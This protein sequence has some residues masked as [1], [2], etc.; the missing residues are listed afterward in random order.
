MTYTERLRAL[1]N[2][3][4]GR[5]GREVARASRLMRGAFAGIES[6]TT[7][8]VGRASD[9]AMLDPD[10]LEELKQTSPSMAI[11][12]LWLTRHRTG[13]GDYPRIAQVRRSYAEP[14]PYGVTRVVV[15]MPALVDHSLSLTMLGEAAEAFPSAELCCF[16]DVL[17][18]RAAARTE[19]AV[20]SMTGRHAQVDGN[21]RFGSARASGRRLG[22]LLRESDALT[23]DAPSL[24]PPIVARSMLRQADNRPAPPSMTP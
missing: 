13:N 6:K 21:L 24:F 22:R 17:C 5:G 23:P 7:A 19:A 3:Y 14:T 10:E 15:L 9:L 11:Y 20:Y 16:A 2:A 8:L 1:S 12:C 4:T 18:E